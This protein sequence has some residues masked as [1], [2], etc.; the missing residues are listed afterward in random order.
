[1]PIV[2]SIL[3][4]MAKRKIRDRVC[5]HPIWQEYQIELVETPKA[6]VWTHPGSLHAYLPR[7]QGSDQAEQEHRLLLEF[8]PL[9]CN[10]PDLHSESLDRASGQLIDAFEA[11]LLGE[12]NGLNGTILGFEH[13]LTQIGDNE[14]Y[15]SEQEARSALEAD[16]ACNICCV[17]GKKFSYLFDYEPLLGVWPV[18]P[19]DCLYVW[20]DD[21]DDETSIYGVTWWVQMMYGE[22]AVVV[23]ARSR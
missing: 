17:R 12:G 10:M 16:W 7:S 14:I 1:M 5:S 21:T 4:K 11:G 6:E 8:A 15:E 3:L 22:R 2:E 9:K 13:Y 18:V 19:R 23:K 20:K